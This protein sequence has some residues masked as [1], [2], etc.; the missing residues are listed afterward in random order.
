MAQALR[1][2]GLRPGGWLSLL[3]MAC[4]LP[5]SARRGS[6]F[7]ALPLTGEGQ[8]S[9]KVSLQLAARDVLYCLAGNYG[10]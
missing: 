8:M 10:H 1:P 4:G 3:S 7:S 2:E 6:K 5:W 9:E